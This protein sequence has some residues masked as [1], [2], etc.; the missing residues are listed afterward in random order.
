MNKYNYSTSVP[1]P[2][3]MKMYAELMGNHK[4]AGIKSLADNTNVVDK[5]QGFRTKDL[6]LIHI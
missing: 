2:Y 5:E 3:W 6:S 1:H 4:N